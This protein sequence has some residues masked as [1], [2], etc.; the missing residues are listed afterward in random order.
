MYKFVFNLFVLLITAV[1]ATVSDVVSFG[2]V[3][4]AINAGGDS[5]TD[6]LGIRYEKDPLFNKV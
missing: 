6:S 3:I 2:E 1:L 5:F 4:Y